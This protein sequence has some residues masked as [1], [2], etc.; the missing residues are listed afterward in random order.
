MLVAVAGAVDLFSEK[1]VK[2]LFQ[3]N[4]A[5]QAEIITKIYQKNS[6]QVPLP[7]QAAVLLAIRGIHTASRWFP[8]PAKSKKELQKMLSFLDRDLF[9][10]CLPV[11]RADDFI[12]NDRRLK[13]GKILFLRFF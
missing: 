2:K 3:L 12:E 10:L 13:E 7:D 8:F 4:L 9:F 11:N 6:A 1:G 5:E